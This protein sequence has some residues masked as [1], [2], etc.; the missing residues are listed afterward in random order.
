M[1]VSESSGKARE[2]V[3]AGNHMGRCVWL[4]DVGSHISK[5]W[6]KTSRKVLIGF[7]LPKVRR[8]FNEE[9]G[10]EPALLSSQYT[11]SL[12]DKAMLRADLES[13]RGRKFTADELK[14]FDLKNI[15]GKAGL[16]NV[17]HTE[18]EGKHYDNIK[19]ITPLMEGMTCPPRET[20]TIHF[21]LDAPNW[22]VYRKLPEW[23]QKKIESSPEWGKPEY[24]D[25][26][27]AD[28][29]Q[30]SNV[31]HDNGFSGPGHE[32]ENLDDLDEVPF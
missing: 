10:E 12:S 8:V 14:G 21:E 9:K 31:S 30:G 1:I 11:A 23:V 27:P 5:Q 18:H 29:G 25:D 19:T 4:I 24:M 6:G 17:V 22:D 32:A 28:I 2:L 20:E 3:P 26:R 16:V 13:W 15:L 7:E